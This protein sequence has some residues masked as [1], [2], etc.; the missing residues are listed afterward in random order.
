MRARVW[1]TRTS[2]AHEHASRRAWCCVYGVV[3][4]RAALPARCISESF[5]FL[6]CCPAV[7]SSCWSSWQPAKVSLA[8]SFCASR[9]R[10]LPPF[11][12][13]PPVSVLRV[14]YHVA[15]LYCSIVHTLH[16]FHTSPTLCPVRESIPTPL[17]CSSHTHV[18]T[19]LV[20]LQP[21]SIPCLYAHNT[22][23]GFPLYA[24]QIEQ[25]LARC[26]PFPPIQLVNVQVSVNFIVDQK[27]LV[28]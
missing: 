25:L 4:G 9:H 8:R 21:A 5:R 2:R 26:I 12:C 18:R 20:R 28:F 3:A 19:V 11:R 10:N 15:H 27:Y 23:A 16:Y 13:V 22:P 1:R 17:Y 6:L 7:P 24:A 14:S